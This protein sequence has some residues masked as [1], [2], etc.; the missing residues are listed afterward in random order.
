HMNIIVV[1]DHGMTSTPRN[2][3]ILLDRIID[4]DHVHVVAMG[5]LA[6][7]TSRPGHAEEV[8]TRL[9]KP[10]PHMTCWRKQDIPARHHYGTHPRIPALDCLADDGWQ[11]SSSDYLA[12]RKFP[13]SLGN[14]GYDNA[15]PHM[16]ALFI[17]HGPAFRRG[18]RVPPFPNVDVYPLMTHLLGIM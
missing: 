10:H 11:I 5:I 4:L 6:G 8:A 1:S 18:V 15:D 7:V 9:L 2:Q 3:V 13:L 16:R 12:H 17:A 14:H